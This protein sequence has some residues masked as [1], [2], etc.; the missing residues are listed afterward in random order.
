M[1]NNNFLQKC[2]MIKENERALWLGLDQ[3]FL[4]SCQLKADNK[5][6]IVHLTCWELLLS[7]SSFIQSVLIFPYFIAKMLWLF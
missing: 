3:D 6:I 2:D 1:N 7:S 4:L 5:I